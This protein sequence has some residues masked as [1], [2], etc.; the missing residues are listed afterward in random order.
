MGQCAVELLIRLIRGETSDPI[1][2]TLATSL[3]VR[4]S[5]RAIDHHSR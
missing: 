5:T 1:H 2:L 3:V 4:Q